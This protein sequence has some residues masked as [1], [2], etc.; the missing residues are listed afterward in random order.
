M[1]AQKSTLSFSYHRGFFFEF[2]WAFFN[3]WSLLQHSMAL[4][5]QLGSVKT[6]MHGG[7]NGDKDQMWPY[8]RAW[9]KTKGY[10]MDSDLSSGDQG[11]FQ[12]VCGSYGDQGV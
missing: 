11:L 1:A 9:S 10:R 8:L 5:H 3:D 4:V 7:L 6:T 2:S 12:V